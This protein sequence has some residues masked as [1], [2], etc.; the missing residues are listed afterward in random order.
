MIKS[1]LARGVAVLAV[2]G[3]RKQPYARR[4]LTVDSV[5]SEQPAGENFA[6]RVGSKFSDPRQENRK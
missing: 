5:D 2:C 4:G 6:V 1:Y 3:V